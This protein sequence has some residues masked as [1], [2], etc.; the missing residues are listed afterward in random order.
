MEKN[1]QKQLEIIEKSNAWIRNSLEG[2]KQK[3]AYRNMVNCRRELNKKK[4]ALEDNPAAAVFGDSQVGKSYLIDALLCD[5]GNTFSITDNDGTVYGFKKDMNPIGGGSES[6][7]LV[8][9][10]STKYKPINLKYPIKAKLLSPADLVLVLCDSY[11]NDI[12]GSRDSMLQRE[13]IDTEVQEMKNKWQDRNIQQ[14]VFEEDD[15]LDIQEYVCGNFETKAVNLSDYFFKEISLLIAKVQPEEWKDIFSL[16]WNKNEKFTRLFSNLISEY[17]KLN[18]TDTLYLPLEAVLYKHGTLL[19][20]TRIKELYETKTPEQIE[21]TK[22][23]VTEYKETTD[24]LIIENTIEREKK[25]ISKSYLCALSAE[26]I[27]SLP[28][29]LQTNKPFLIKTD[30]LDFPGARA[31]KTTPEDDI[32]ENG[33]SELLIRGKVAYL[34]NKYSNF[35]KINILLFCAKHTQPEERTMPQILAPLVK[36]IIGKDPQS[37][38]EFIQKSKISPLFIIGTFFNENLKRLPAD[39]KDDGGSSLNYR[40]FQRFDSTLAAELI[41]TETYDWF[42]N[43]TVSDPNFRNIFLLR[44]YEYSTDIFEGF[45]KT[46]LKESDKKPDPEDYPGFSDKLRQSFLDYDFVK[47]HFPEPQSE[48]WDAAADMNKDGTDLIIKKLTIAAE[49]I[50]P[51]RMAKMRAELDEISQT[52]LAEL[53]KHFHDDDKDKNLQKAK[54]MAGDIQR[55]LD[56]A[57]SADGI[58]RYGQMMKEFMLDEGTVLKLFREKV[59]DI[60]YRGVVNEDVYNLYRIRVPVEK[61]DTKDK[62]FERLCVAYEKTTEERKAEFR[63]ELEAEEIDLEKL[64]KGNSDLINDN[65]QQLAKALL[66]FWFKSLDDKPLIQQ[67]LGQDAS[68]GNIKD[69]YKTLFGEKQLKLSDEIAEKIRHHVKTDSPYE[70]VADISTELLNKCINTVG[71]EYLDESEINELRQANEKNNLCLILDNNTNPTE[72]SLE[73]LFTK[74]ENQT[75]IMTEQPEEMKSLPSYRNYL[76]WSNRLKVGFVSVCDIPNFDLTA[77]ANL[78]K[79]MEECKNIKY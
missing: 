69:M 14:N 43:W 42:K 62:Y 55:K 35:E 78:G 41:D 60:G 7:I 6:T 19:D 66:E 26:L 39:N 76:A 20:V 8:S 79:I 53:Q 52:I 44:D 47:R 22:K 38:E 64:I 36:K 30:L 48:S 33:M 10:F 12:K 1:I 15:V 45:S 50:I 24:A 46:T 11:Y 29:S 57:F 17:S 72:N 67:I 65:A 21:K 56:I 25:S 4:F 63:A 59:D 54:N 73:E 5:Q 2:N 9:R 31:R 49:N 68:L 16:L 27:F 58:K 18:F 71:F 74:I 3:D 40:W 23:T 37:R 34:F 13:D 61:D 32:V 75:K 51:A 28:E 77:N 70:I